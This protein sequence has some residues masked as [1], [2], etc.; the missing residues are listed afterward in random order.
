MPLVLYKTSLIFYQVKRNRFKNGA[1]NLRLVKVI[2]LFLKRLLNIVLTTFNHL[3]VH[4]SARWTR[5]EFPPPL[6]CN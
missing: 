5:R 2:E 6:S 4:H 1:N 3:I